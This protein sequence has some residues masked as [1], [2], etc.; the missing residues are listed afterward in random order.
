MNDK[1]TKRTRLPG[2]CKKEGQ[3]LQHYQRAIPPVWFPKLRAIP[4]LRP[5]RLFDRSFE[6]TWH[7]KSHGTNVNLQI[8]VVVEIQANQVVR[9]RVTTNDYLLQFKFTIHKRLRTTGWFVR[10]DFVLLGWARNQQQ[11]VEQRLLGW[12]RYWIQ[13]GVCRSNLQHGPFTIPE[14]SR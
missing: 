6:S 10:T 4:P 13:H 1:E 8:G 11:S 3:D 5:F 7:L 12:E 2:E 9:S 14:A